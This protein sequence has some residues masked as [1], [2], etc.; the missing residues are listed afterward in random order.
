MGG[1]DSELTPDSN[2]QANDS[3]KD[4]HL[5]DDKTEDDDEVW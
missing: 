4:G 5:D 1:S 2:P 3:V